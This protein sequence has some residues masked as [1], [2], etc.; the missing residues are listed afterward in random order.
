MVA[1]VT[2][3]VLAARGPP[4]SAPELR[5]CGSSGGTATARTEAGKSPVTTGLSGRRRS[6]W[7]SERRVNP[8]SRPGGHATSGFGRGSRPVKTRG[9]RA[10]CPPDRIQLRRFCLTPEEP[11]P[12][13]FDRADRLAVDACALLARSGSPAR[14]VRKPWFDG[15]PGTRDATVELGVTQSHCTSTG[16]LVD[17]ADTGSPAW[18][19][20]AVLPRHSA[21]VRGE[22]DMT[23]PGTGGGRCCG[24]TPSCRPSDHR[25]RAFG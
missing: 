14:F 23:V 12:F 22:R 4:A 1:D 15:I 6:L 21:Q 5:G 8:S 25:E 19:A 24:D 3:L 17:V 7:S 10:L 9:N 13:S 20:A 18:R 11:H 16:S 2:A